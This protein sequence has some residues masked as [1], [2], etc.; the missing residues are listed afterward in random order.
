MTV[1]SNVR[2]KRLTATG[3]SA[4]GRSRIAAINVVTGAGA[5][6]VTITSGNGG[7]TLLDLDTAASATQ[8][9]LLPEGGILSDADPYISTLTNV[10]SVTLMVQ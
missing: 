7:A 8:Y 1:K 2:T 5:G 3:A 10:T 4:L 6:R 9:F